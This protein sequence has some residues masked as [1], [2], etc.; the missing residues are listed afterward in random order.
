MANNLDTDLIVDVLS[1]VALTTLPSKLANLRAYSTDVTDDRA[2]ARQKIQ[3]ELVTGVGDVIENPTNFQVTAIT[4]TNVEVALTHLSRPVGLSAQDLNVGHKL[5]TK[6]RK[7]LITLADAVQDKIFQLVTLT[8]F[9]N[10]PTI[11]GAGT[12]AE[13]LK[14]MWGSILG[15][16]Q[17]NAVL[18]TSQYANYLPTNL[19][20]FDPTQ[21]TAGIFGFDGFF[22]GDRLA[23]AGESGIL[24]FA[25]DPSAIA[26]A[27]RLPEDPG[28]AK[29]ADYITSQTVTVPD[30]GVAVEFNVWF[31]R[32]SRGHW[33]SYDICFGAAVGDPT[34]LTIAMPTT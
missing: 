15:G 6:A 8:N 30:L 25:C 12:D 9:T 31:D 7:A 28:G 1:D 19:E 10:S 3:V 11:K 18:T 17:K 13:L 23:A 14:A 32:A 21:R 33:L 22:Y 5:E 2:K 34:A 24:G 29:G 26:V 16:G 27:A 4:N 20:S